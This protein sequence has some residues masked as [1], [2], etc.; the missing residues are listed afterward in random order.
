MPE[1]SD[2]HE[3]LDLLDVPLTWTAADRAQVELHLAQQR[4]LLMACH[5]LDSK[6]RA[7]LARIVERVEAA[8]NQS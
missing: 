2:Y 8:L 4:E 7:S 5:P 3:F 6:R 1:T